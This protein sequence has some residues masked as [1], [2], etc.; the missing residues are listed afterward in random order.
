MGAMVNSAHTELDAKEKLANVGWCWAYLDV[1]HMI[2]AGW[3]GQVIRALGNSP[4]LNTC[5]PRR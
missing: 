4:S 1:F 3:K 5:D 2:V